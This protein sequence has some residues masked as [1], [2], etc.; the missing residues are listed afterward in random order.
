MNANPLGHHADGQGALTS[1]Y[2]NVSTELRN[3]LSQ[4]ER[5]NCFVFRRFQKVS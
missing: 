4:A 1:R 2:R 5:Q 3:G